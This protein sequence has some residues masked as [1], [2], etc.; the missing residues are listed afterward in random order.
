MNLQCPGQLPAPPRRSLGPHP[1]DPFTNYTLGGDRNRCYDG[2]HDWNQVQAAPYDGRYVFPSPAYVAAHPLSARARRAAG[3]T[4]V[5]LP[6]G[7]YV[8]EAVTPPGYEVVKEEDKNILIGDA[9]V[10]PATQQFGPLASIFILPDQATLGNANPYNPGTG[11]PGLQ[12]DPTTQPGRLRR[13][14]RGDL[15]GVRG[16]P[17]PRARLPEPLPA[18]PAGRPLRRAWTGRSATASRSC[19]TTRCSRARPSSSSPRCPWPPTTPASSSTTRP[20]SSTPSS[21]DFG[22]KATVPFVPVSI[23]DFTGNEISRTYSDQWGAYNMMTPS[24]WLV[25]PPTPS[26]YGPNML[27]TCMNDPGPIPDPAT[28]DKLIT[29][30]AYNPA[31][32]NF[33][34]TNP[35]MPGQTTYLDTPVLPIAAFAAGYNP[36]DCALPDAAPGHPPGRQQRRLRP[37][38][39]RH[40]AAPSPSPPRATSRC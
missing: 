35:F 24:S 36:A 30:P 22:E 9:F 13:L 5:S 40:A 26:G 18:G 27:V 21:P 37:V 17:A 14:Q 6:P 39:A 3:Q 34:Y 33:C 38:A 23:K 32:S 10:A 19:S 8:V 16:Q 12:S 29:D 2:W 1:V 25:N 31:Y 28:P 20:R 7:T 15:P 4:L 11:D